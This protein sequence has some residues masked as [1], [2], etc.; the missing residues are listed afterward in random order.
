MGNILSDPSLG[1]VGANVWLSVAFAMFNILF[2]VLLGV[3]VCGL[4]VGITKSK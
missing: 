1:K 4:G 2:F 3:L